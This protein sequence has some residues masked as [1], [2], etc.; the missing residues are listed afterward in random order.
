MT[1]TERIYLR[2]LAA[3]Q[4]EIA[5]LPLMETRR[6]QWYALNDGG[7]TARPP[8]IIEPW[9]FA[10]EFLPEEV[11]RCE[12][13]TARG[14][15]RQLLGNIRN[16]ELLD[17]DKV[18]PGTFDIGWH[19]EIDEFGVQVGF[20]HA[21]DQEG[22]RLGFQMLHPLKDLERDLD[23]LQPARCRVDRAATE[24]W[25]G[26]VEELLGDLLPV[27][28]R[29]GAFGHGMLT[30]RVVYLMGMEAYFLA[31]YDA[32]D[33]L[34]R[35]MAFLR[36]NALRMM[37]WAEAEGLLICNNENQTSFGSSFNFTEC[38]PAPGYNGTR[39]R[40]RDM[41]G[42]ANSQETVGV[43]AELFHEF[44]WPYYRDVCA[45]L[46]LVYYGC[47][48]P[49][50]PFWGDLQHLPNL[51]KVSISKWCNQSVMG[52]ALRGTGIIFSRKPDPNLLGVDEVLDE[53]AWRTHIRES[54]L[55]APHVGKEFIVRDVYTVHHNL[56]KCKRA[57]Q[58][59]R[60]EIDRMG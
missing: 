23:L 36:D 22:R 57:V 3:R 50:D 59:A 26:F 47:C 13:P 16:H 24:A 53:D 18:I 4:A 20:E 55:A 43:S 11:L 48:E 46:G 38:L 35:L 56:A 5:T 25:R 17:D 21:E 2:E 12:S 37:F 52:E 33:A 40:L 30:H 7:A 42:C 15:E 51:K 29:S 58:L 6:R 28:L 14:I 49:V 9:T 32:P 1:A 10:G 41:W 8:V 27:T 39:A 54:L 44:C 60:E 34:H 19:V 31:M 45:P